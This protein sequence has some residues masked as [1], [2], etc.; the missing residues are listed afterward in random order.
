MN[1]N[2]KI[3]TD[4]LIL[5]LDAADKKSYSGSGTTWYDRSGG[6]HDGTLISG[7]THSTDNGGLF[8]FDGVNDYVNCPATNSVIGEN[9]SVISLS[10]WV[11]LTDSS[12]A[13]VFNCKRTSGGSTLVG[14][15]ANYNDG[16]GSL[17]ALV[18]NNADSN[19]T[20]YD[21]N[22]SYNDGVWHNLVFTVGATTNSL[23]IDGIL[24]DSDTGVGIQSVS[25]NTGTITVGSFGHAYWLNGNIASCCIY[26]KTLSA[27]EI[28]Q[29][30][31]AMRGRFGV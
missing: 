31:N 10:G 19:H 26:N 13:Y 18:R 12:S 17:G 23:Y 21:H 2:P 7:P 25:G 16:E 3:V 24:R 11:K 20:W 4:G 8:G 6:D 1:F 28:L 27:S 15:T 30:F 14:L 5:C 22:G 9:I 29:N